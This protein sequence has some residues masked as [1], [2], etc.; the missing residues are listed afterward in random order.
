MPYTV[1]FSRKWYILDKVSW[2][3]FQAGR[4]AVEFR[5]YQKFK[6]NK[7]NNC[8]PHTVLYAQDVSSVVSA[9]PTQ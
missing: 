4:S 8:R 5:N 6:E 2:C 3:V 9:C 1:Y 7:T